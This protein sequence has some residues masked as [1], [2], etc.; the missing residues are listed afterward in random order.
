MSALDP[1]NIDL[2]A[3]RPVKNPDGSISTVRSMSF[4][5]DGQ[6]VLI[7]TVVGKRVVSDRR[8]I[9]EYRRTGRHLGK[10]GSVK[11]ANAYAQ[12][13]HKDYES[14]KFNK[15]PSGPLYD[16][17]QRSWKPTTTLRQAVAGNQ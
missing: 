1:G 3:K 4:D 16:L 17:L 6:E 8:A 10:F 13:L 14:G 2:Y 5:E 7:P 11:E 9:T 15:R 12:Q